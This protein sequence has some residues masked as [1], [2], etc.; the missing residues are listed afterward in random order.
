M[1][2]PNINILDETD[3]VLRTK[4][5]DV[6]FPLSKEEKKLINDSL[7]YLEMSQIDNYREKYDLRAGMGL[8]FIQLGIPKRIFV[9]SEEIDENKF[10]RHIVINPKIKSES[11]ELI[12][13]GEGEGCLSVNREVDGIVPRHAR[14]TIEAYDEEGIFFEIRVREDMAV[15]FQHELDHLNGIL[16][17]DRIDK[18]NPYKNRNIMREI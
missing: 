13:V 9:I 14:I 3:K 10:N 17:I 7:D 16:F 6:K 4:S 12:F 18:S 15:A 11:E 5:F 2:L 1:K 8:S